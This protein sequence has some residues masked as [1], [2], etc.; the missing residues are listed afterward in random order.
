MRHKIGDWVWCLICRKPV[1]L[2]RLSYGL[3]FHTGYVYAHAYR[4]L[5][6]D[7]RKTV[8]EKP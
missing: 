3:C 8:E 5:T 4:E 7:E 6:E 1:Q 2:N